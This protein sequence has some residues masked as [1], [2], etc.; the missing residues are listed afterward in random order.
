MRQNALLETFRAGDVATAA[1]VTI[2]DPFVGE[3]MGR[4]GL[5]VLLVDTEHSAMSPSQLQGLLMAIYPSDPTAIVRVSHND[6]IPI[7]QA[8]DLGAEGVLVPGIDSADDCAAMVQSAFYAP[9]GSRGLGPR[10]VSR[11]HGDR[12]DYLKR[13]NDE[14][15]VLAMVESIQGVEAINDILG[16]EGLSGIFIGLADLAVSM[17]HLHDLSHP[18]VDE[19]AREIAKAAVAAGVPFGVFTVS[20]TAAQGWIE[21]G[22]QLVAVGADL[23][24]IDAGLAQCEA[25]SGRLKA[26]QG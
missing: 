5:D 10:R 21:Q 11:L 19:A 6:P 14:I 23:M 26:K 4:A 24:F 16:V 20:E 1:W 17:G 25:L 8:L 2:P 12:A 13:A 18:D 9:K 7:K 22:A 3:V 15:A